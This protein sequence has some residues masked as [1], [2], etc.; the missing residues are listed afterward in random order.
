MTRPQYQPAFGSASLKTAA[1]GTGIGTGF[2]LT[3]ET[4]VFPFIK[5]LADLEPQTLITALVT[6]GG[7]NIDFSWV[8]TALVRLASLARPW[9]EVIGLLA[10]QMHRFIQTQTQAQPQ[11]QAGA[12]TGATAFAFST[13]TGG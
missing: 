13:T 3:W 1:R 9:A 2:G 7:L 11:P 8:F 5:Q 4:L 6:L 12:E 10:S